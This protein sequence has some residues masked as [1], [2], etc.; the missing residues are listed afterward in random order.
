MKKCKICFNKKYAIV[1]TSCG[2]KLCINCI[3]CLTKIECPFCRKSLVDELPKRQQQQQQRQQ[4]N[5]DFNIP[6]SLFETDFMFSFMF[7]TFL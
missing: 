5:A 7:S 3:M 4:H 2:H 1:K 6:F